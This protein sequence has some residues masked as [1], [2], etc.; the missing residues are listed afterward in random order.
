MGCGDRESGC[1]GRCSRYAEW[2]KVMDIRNEQAR[3]QNVS[4]MSD[5]KK[6]AIWR[7]KRY[8]RGKPHVTHRMTET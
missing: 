4:T 6:K 8:G 3:E 7:S 2:R 1:H 5:A